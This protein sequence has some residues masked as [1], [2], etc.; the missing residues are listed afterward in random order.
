MDFLLGNLMAPPLSSAASVFDGDANRQ[1]PVTSRVTEWEK[2][3][4][5]FQPVGFAIIMLI[6]KRSDAR[7]GAPW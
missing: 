4:L 3:H 5:G 7:K 6:K 1:A 2:R